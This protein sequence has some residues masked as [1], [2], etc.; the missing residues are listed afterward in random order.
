MLWT[1]P[2]PAF[3]L[4]N[5]ER[6]RGRDPSLAGPQSVRRFQKLSYLF[7]RAENPLR[8]AEEG[9]AN[10][11]QRDAAAATVEKLDAVGRFEFP[12]LGRDRRLAGVQVLR[13]RG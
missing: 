7:F 2:P 4:H 13:G 10:S 6:P 5:I 12:D 11:R 8:H 1:A 9:L 3:H